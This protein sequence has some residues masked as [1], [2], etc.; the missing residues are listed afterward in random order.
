V[1]SAYTII[2]GNHLSCPF[3]THYLTRH[4]VGQHRRQNTSLSNPSKHMKT[5]RLFAIS[6][7]SVFTFTI[8]V[9]Y[10]LC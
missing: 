4:C 8:N 3:V 2:L 5:L 9:L 1:S 6:D 7:H 10:S